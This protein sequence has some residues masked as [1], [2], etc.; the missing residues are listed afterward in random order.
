MRVLA[1]FLLARLVLIGPAAVWGAPVAH[2]TAAGGRFWFFHVEN[3]LRW[4]LPGW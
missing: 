2:S 3:G 1:G 4:Q